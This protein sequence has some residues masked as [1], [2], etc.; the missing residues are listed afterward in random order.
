MRRMGVLAII[1]VAAVTAAPALSAQTF[2]VND[3]GLTTNLVNAARSDVGLHTLPRNST[4]DQ[5]ARDQSVRMAERGEIYHNPRLG[6]EAT[7]RGLDW[8]LLGENVGVGPDAE[9]IHDA[10]MDS[11]PHYD[12]IVGSDFNAV[13][14]G[15]VEAGSRIYITH[16][17]AQLNSAPAPAPAQAPAPEPQVAAAP[18]PTAQPATAPPAPT[19]KPAP[20]AT[21]EPL[22]PTPNALVGGVVNLELLVGPPVLA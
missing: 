2:R 3:E 18:A 4:L 6:E 21:P 12:N 17:F 9:T 5:M 1:F 15:V 20:V 11:E 19:P 13:G 22:T 8:R 7:E 14:I 10:F 16:V